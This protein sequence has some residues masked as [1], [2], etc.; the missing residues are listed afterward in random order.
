MRGYNIF[1]VYTMDNQFS[2]TELLFGCEAMAK[3]KTSSVAIFGVGGVGGHVVEVLAR[4]GIGH[5][6]IIDNDKVSLTNLNRQ[7]IA[8]HSTLGEYKVDVA[9]KRIHDINP[10]CTVE[11]HRMFYLPENAGNIDLKCY[12][13]VVD[14]ID[15]I[16]AK[17]E[18]VR[19]CHELSIPIISSMGA[20]NKIDATAFR[21]C[22]ISKTNV[23]PLAKFMRKKLKK[24]GIE[25]L[26]VVFSDEVPIKTPQELNEG[27]RPIPASN[28]FVP[29][30]VGL[31]IGGEVI[32]DIVYK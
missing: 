1:E 23:D 7:I 15:T 24:I 19:R 32:K 9:K 10:E 12:D 4:T 30:A 29:A 3:L 6:A 20:A 2:R 31:I 5:I 18:L 17:I 22:D 28:A 16:T 14:C 13:Y 25:N 27:E 21:V 8:L 11:A 26:K